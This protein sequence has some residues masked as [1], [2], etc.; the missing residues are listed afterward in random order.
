MPNDT[1]LDAVKTFYDPHPGFAGASIPIPGPVK[2]AAEALDGKTMSLRDAI[3]LIQAAT[4]GRVEDVPKHGYIA[5]R[6]GR[7]GST[8]HLFRVI[9]YR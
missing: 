8:E 3:A 5:L 6:L 7:A 1:D 2:K 9:K 4:G